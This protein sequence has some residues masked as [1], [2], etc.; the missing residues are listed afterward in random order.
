MFP[1]YSFPDVAGVILVLTRIVYRKREKIPM[2]LVMKEFWNS[3]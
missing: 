1:G 2:N 3:E